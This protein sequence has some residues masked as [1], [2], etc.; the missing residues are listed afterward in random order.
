M[1]TGLRHVTEASPFGI[2]WG[3]GLRASD[4]DAAD[5]TIWRSL[6]LLGIALERVRAML[7]QAPTD[8]FDDPVAFT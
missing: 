3:I 1:N 6:N 4:P 8:K 2:E 5:P 7:R